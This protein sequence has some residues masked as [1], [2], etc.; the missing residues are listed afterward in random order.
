MSNM[1]RPTTCGGKQ[2]VR[3]EVSGGLCACPSARLLTPKGRGE[4]VTLGGCAIICKELVNV[5][6]VRLN[7]KGWRV[8]DEV[9]W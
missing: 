5:E 6:I 2:M 1:L 3:P 8:R 4:V 9:L 7:R